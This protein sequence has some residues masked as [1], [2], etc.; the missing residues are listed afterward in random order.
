MHHANIVFGHIS[1]VFIL[2]G[3][4]PNC[5]QLKIPIIYNFCEIFQNNLIYRA[6]DNYWLKIGLRGH[7]EV[8]E[9]K[10][11]DRF[12]VLYYFQHLVEISIFSLE[13]GFCH[14][15]SMR[16]ICG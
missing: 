3:L 1:S 6:R 11:L 16:E 7:R 12:H 2:L 10:S 14:I 9:P 5:K 8:L 4:N 15:H 13:D